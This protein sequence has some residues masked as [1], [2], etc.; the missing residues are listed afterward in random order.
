MGMARTYTA[1]ARGIDAIGINPASLVFYEK[2][3]TVS[4]AVAPMGIYFGNNFLDLDTYSTYFTGVD[5]GGPKRVGKFLTDQD[6]QDILGRFPSDGPASLY[7]D[8]G[9]RLMAVSWHYP[10]LGSFAFAVTERISS[11]ADMPKDYIKFVLYGTEPGSEYSFKETQ[12]KAWW[13]REYSVSYAHL[14]KGIPILR[15]LS[16]GADIKLVH[17]FGYFG[18][19]RFDNHINTGDST[20]FYALK[21]S[22]NMDIL[23]AGADVL[24][25]QSDVGF[26]L[27][28]NPVG[29]GF[30][31]DVGIAA[32]VD[33]VWTVGLSVTD[34][35]SVSWRSNAIETFIDSTLNITNLTSV[36][37]RDSL[38]N[39]MRGRDRKISGFSTPSQ[40]L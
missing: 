16:V 6:K 4:F 5:T 30:G 10:T 13:L 3:T 39:A 27:F 36:E 15:D 21:A 32:K 11:E 9:V 24:N 17:G 19:E 18:I 25:K 8:Y 1:V 26:T 38:Q 34:I 12:V 33:Q 37:Q 31:F 20:N 14:L 40:A 7:F 35:G 22:M 23:R 28:P 2:N 29:S